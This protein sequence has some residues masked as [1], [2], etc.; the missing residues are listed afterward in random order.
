VSPLQ[1]ALGELASCQRAN[2]DPKAALRGSRVLVG[3]ES[4]TSSSPAK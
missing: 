1:N 4:G 2:T 3:D